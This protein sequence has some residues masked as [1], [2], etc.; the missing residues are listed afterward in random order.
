MSSDL[1]LIKGKEGVRKIRYEKRRDATGRK[2][3][4]SIGL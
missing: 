1:D 2:Y 3:R 4:N